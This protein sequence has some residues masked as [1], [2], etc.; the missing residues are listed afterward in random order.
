MMECEPTAILF[1][2]WGVM[3]GLWGV[4]MGLLM[5]GKHYDRH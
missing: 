1:F 2:L 5:D 4:A 3:M